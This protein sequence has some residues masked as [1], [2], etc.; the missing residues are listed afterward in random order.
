MISRNIIS[1]I[2]KATITNN[3]GLKRLISTSVFL[4]QKASV[5]IPRPNVTSKDYKPPV[6]LDRELPDPFRNKKLNRRYFVAYAIGI[7]LSCIFIFNYEKTQSPIITST[8]YF[9]RRS[10]P[11]TDSL[12]KDIDFTSSW[13]WIWGTLNT[14]QGIID[15]EFKVQ[16]SKG[17]GVVKLNATRE[18][19]LHPFD[20]H[21]F[22]LEIDNKDGSKQIIDLTQDPNIDFDL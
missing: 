4:S 14:V 22:V 8:L 15:I 13:P 5:T 7:T 11:S 1:S 17:A 3:L 16:G 12:G 21:A 10:Q 6:T 18:S 2:R 19:K 20:V 9:L